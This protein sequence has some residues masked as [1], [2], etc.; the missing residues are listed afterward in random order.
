MA[1]ITRK[2]TS[3]N[4]T[5]RLVPFYTGILFVVG[6]VLLLWSSYIIRGN[7]G[8]IVPTNVSGVYEFA[9]KDE[10]SE[11]LPDVMRINGTAIH[12]GS[13]LEYPFAVVVDNNS[14]VDKQYGL[15]DAVIVYEMLVE[16]GFTRYLAIYQNS[17]VGK[18]GP[19][20]SARD[21]MLPW[22]LEYDADFVHSGGS[23]KALSE[24]RSMNI[25]NIEEISF[26][27]TRFFWRDEGLKSPH[28]LFTSAEFM[29][30][31]RDYRE[32]PSSPDTDILF[33]KFSAQIRDIRLEN[34][35]SGSADRI[36]IDWGYV[37][38][39][40][41]S[42]VYN[43]EYSTYDR[44]VNEEKDFD[45]GTNTSISPMTVVV[46]RVPEEVV[47]DDEGRIRIDVTGKGELSVFA[48][49]MRIDGSWEKPK[50]DSRTKYFDSTGNEIV[51]Y[52]GQIWVEVVPS[53]KEVVSG[54]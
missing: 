46:L 25:K 1:R 26:L 9:K 22:V 14:Q 16:G 4:D 18:I 19:V 35:I 51:F 48:R 31:A 44:Y 38:S 52:P 28:N 33:G 30:Q 2:K 10:G 6:S 34:T 17:V 32:Y 40:D 39:P 50:R 13:S 47:V 27:G 11:K 23:P 43:P 29:T 20:R 21:Y 7:V 53:G 8:D 36:S 54:V 45:Y 42:Y 49:G 3:V 41:V 12:D 37:T 15:S 24:I 5:D